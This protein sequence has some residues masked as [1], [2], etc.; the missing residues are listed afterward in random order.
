MITLSSE[1]F[2][3]ASCFVH[4]PKHWG[5]SRLITRREV[6]N[7]IKSKKFFKKPIV[8]KVSRRIHIERIAYLIVYGFK[9][10]VLIEPPN[11]KG[12]SCFSD[13][14][15]RVAASV[16]KGIDIECEVFY[17]ASYLKELGKLGEAIEKEYKKTPNN[18]K[19]VF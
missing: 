15:H 12:E 11:K 7:C 1:C 6:S 10:L 13:G 2:I 16:Y 18:C 3:E 14:N 8:G 4:T 9:G 5:Y 17:R 19:G